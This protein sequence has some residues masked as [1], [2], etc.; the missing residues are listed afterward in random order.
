MKTA[1]TSTKIFAVAIFFSIL[2]SVY[3][4]E[5]HDAKLSGS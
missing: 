2:T 3:A 1:G 5:I 4:G